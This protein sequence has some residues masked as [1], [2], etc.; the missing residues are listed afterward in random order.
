MV[1]L[2]FMKKLLALLLL[3]C[4][5][6]SK[7]S[8][9]SPS[10]EPLHALESSGKS[11][12]QI[13]MITNELEFISRSSLAGVPSVLTSCASVSTDTDGAFTVYTLD[14]NDR[15]CTDGKVR[16]GDMQI[17]VN[18]GTLDVIIQSLGLFIDGIKVEGIYTF[19]PV[20]KGGVDYTRLLCTSTKITYPNGDR[21]SFSATKLYK[22]NAGKN[23]TTVDD[24]VLEIHSD[25]YFQLLTNEGIFESEITTPPV[26]SYACNERDLLPVSGTVIIT[27]SR[28]TTQV[29]FGDG[30]CTGVSTQE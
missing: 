10:P 28:G 22:W 12:A 21:V 11:L 25:D 16:S 9:P 30:Q 18:P 14:F 6:C 13:E 27:S 19:Q 7:D 29:N 24:D 26:I 15:A 4:V 1:L 20:T 23:T 17:A 3:A 5:A 8:E 2:N